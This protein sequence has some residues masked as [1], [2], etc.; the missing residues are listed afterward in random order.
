[1]LSAVQNA[2]RRDNSS[3]GK[4]NSRNDNNSSR[5]TVEATRLAVDD[6]LVCLRLLRMVVVVCRVH[7]V[8][9]PF[10][11]IQKRA[12]IFDQLE[13]DAVGGRRGMFSCSP[14]C[15]RYSWFLKIQ[16][17]P[18]GVMFKS[19]LS[20]ARDVGMSVPKYQI[21]RESGVRVLGRAMR[22][23][24]AF[25]AAAF[26]GLVTNVGVMSSSLEP[27]MLSKRSFSE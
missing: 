9:G 22:L 26:R 20:N 11:A 12:K 17:L 13:V 3:L 24:T 10:A 25:A 18:S 16:M 23:T 4:T 8:N 2:E 19:E 14:Y 21:N 6:N 15:H 1:M 7:N 27:L 5:R